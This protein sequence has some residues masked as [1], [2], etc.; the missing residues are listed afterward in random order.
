MVPLAPVIYL[1]LAGLAVVFLVT[2][3]DFPAALS[4]RDIG[5]AAFPV[6]L[7]GTMLAL[8][9][10]DLVISRN[11]MRKVPVT[12]PGRAAVA[13]ALLGLVVWAS[14]RIGF[15]YV[16]PVA[17]FAGLWIAGSRSWIANAVFSL[18]LPAVVWL[19]FDQVL[20]IPMST[21]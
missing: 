6:W 7:A 19:L 11:R 5:P 3:G 20:M 9:A 10:A 2:A 8:I 21:L 13:A 1:V 16:L 15:F 18:A 4:A 12:V 14:E 17:V